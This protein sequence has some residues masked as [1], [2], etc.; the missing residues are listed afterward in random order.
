MAAPAPVNLSSDTQQPNTNAILAVGSR[1][2]DYAGSVLQQRKPWSEV[3]DRN[4]FSKPANFA[5]ATS[6]LRKNAAYFRINY[7]ILMMLV[8]A[9]TFITNP[10]SLIVLSMLLAGWVYV[11]A[12]RTTPLVIG[13]RTVSDREKALGMAAIS[14]I[15]V[16]FVTNVGSLAFTALLTSACVVALHGATRV[17]DD[18]FLDEGEAN[19]GLLSFLG[20]PNTAQGLTTIATAV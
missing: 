13:G 2:K 16:F 3:V 18:L 9:I 6:R 7:V 19:Q 10:G 11:F 20:T 4:S 14:F 12:V 5:E 15:T 8:L 17:P 1:L